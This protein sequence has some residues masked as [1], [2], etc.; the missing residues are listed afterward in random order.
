MGG[1]AH[2]RIVIIAS[3]AGILFGFDTAVIAGVTTALREFFSRS[4]AG[5]GAAVS[6]ALWGTLLGA[7]IVGGPGD[8]Y[9]SR[10]M[11]RVVGMLYVIPHGVRSAFNFTSFVLCRFLAGI[12]IGDPRC[13]RRCISPKSRRRIGAVLS[14][15]CSRS[16][17]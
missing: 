16:T 10:N 14:W 3:L 4:P 17:S 8:R 2:F 7:L 12:A 9:G 11:L 1:A 5:L 13:S 6:S 15:V